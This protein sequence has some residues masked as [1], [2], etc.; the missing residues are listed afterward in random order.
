MGLFKKKVSYDP[1]ADPLLKDT[2]KMLG[3]VPGSQMR[4]IFGWTENDD[5]E[6][7]EVGLDK[8]KRKLNEMKASG[9]TLREVME[10]EIL[11]KGTENW[12][13]E[14]KQT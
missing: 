3:L 8:T 9:A 7:Q 14:N 1:F 13:K 2:M 4:E 11:I 10:L 6:S 5:I 12:L